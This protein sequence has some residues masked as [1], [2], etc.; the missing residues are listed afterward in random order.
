M[1]YSVFSRVAKAKFNLLP[2]V[3]NDNTVR[4]LTW[5]WQ[6]DSSIFRGLGDE[7]EP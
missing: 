6:L 2:S 1:T 7:L 4:Q 3:L 5:L